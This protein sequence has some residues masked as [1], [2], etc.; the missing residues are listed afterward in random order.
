MSETFF[1]YYGNWLLPEVMLGQDEMTEESL[2]KEYL[3]DCDWHCAFTLKKWCG[4]VEAA[5]LSPP[6]IQLWI[7]PKRPEPGTR[8]ECS[9][10]SLHSVEC[11]PT[12]RFRG[13][14]GAGS[15]RCWFW[16]CAAPPLQ[17]TLKG[18][19]KTH[20]HA[21]ARTH[22]RTHIFTYKLTRAL[23]SLVSSSRSIASSVVVVWSTVVPLHQ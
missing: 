17:G 18:W 16:F 21:C 20:A 9:I 7:Q 23:W 22:A 5:N 1:E 8:P 4:S 12:W 3:S 6:A 14:R 11:P 19:E 13:L 15:F 2:K 10:S